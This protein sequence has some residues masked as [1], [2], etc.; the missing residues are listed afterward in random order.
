MKSIIDEWPFKK[1]IHLIRAWSL[2]KQAEF[3]LKALFNIV[4]SLKNLSCMVL[5]AI[6]ISDVV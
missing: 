6:S 4:P 1:V 3:T 2:I 5:H